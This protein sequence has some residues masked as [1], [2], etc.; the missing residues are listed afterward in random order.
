[1]T[2]FK[3]NRV[4]VKLDLKNDFVFVISFSFETSDI[5]GSS[6]DFEVKEKR[7]DWF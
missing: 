6:S 5:I 3:V 1:M 7:Y 4:S 2:V